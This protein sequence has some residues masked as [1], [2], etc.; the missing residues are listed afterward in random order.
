[1][2]EQKHDH[3]LPA[4]ANRLLEQ[5]S[6][7]TRQDPPASSRRFE[8]RTDHRLVVARHGVRQRR[9]PVGVGDVGGMPSPSSGGSSSRRRRRARP[10]RLPDAARDRSGRGRRRRV[11]GAPA[12]PRVTLFGA[13]DS[14]GPVV[15]DHRRRG[16]RRREG[17][18]AR[19]ATCRGVVQRG[20]AVGTPDAEVGARRA[21]VRAARRRPMRLATW[22]AG[23]MVRERKSAPAS[24]AKRCARG[25]AVSAVNA[26]S[27]PPSS[28]G[29]P[30]PP[31]EGPMRVTSPQFGPI[32]APFK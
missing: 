31:T 26:A 14:G 21:G 1:M 28:A 15:L 24:S 10:A 25:I 22:T 2:G 19:G 11:R 7:R 6:I 30:P 9:E 4:V 20:V 29:L 5:R 27:L 16:P 23:G 18:G 3:V 8:E 17:C 12:R 13:R 32:R